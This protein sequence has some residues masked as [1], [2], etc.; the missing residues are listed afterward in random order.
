M[1]YEVCVNN[2]W[3]KAFEV[4]TANGPTR[5]PE[6]HKHGEFPG[7]AYGAELDRGMKRALQWCQ[8]PAE[9]LER[10][11]VRGDQQAAPKGVI[12][13]RRPKP[14]VQIGRAHV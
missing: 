8:T 10:E 14:T 7:S 11:A 3:K 9:Q 1:S 4:V 2:T 5:W 12:G 13:S 6:W